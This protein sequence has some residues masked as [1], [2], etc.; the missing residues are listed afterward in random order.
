M[1]CR[2]SGWRGCFF[3]F[4]IIDRQFVCCRTYS[5]AL[6]LRNGTNLL[7]SLLLPSRMTLFLII[8]AAAG[9]FHRVFG[10]TGIRGFVPTKLL[11]SS[12]LFLLP[13]GHSAL[14]LCPWHCDR[15]IH[16]LNDTVGLIFI[17]RAMEDEIAMVNIVLSERRWAPL[18]RRCLEKER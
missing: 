5:T 6:F 8:A 18:Q 4:N 17:K 12:S 7:T 11:T 15:F 9:R 10:E 1:Y 16:Q 2:R 13:L 14:T 3:L